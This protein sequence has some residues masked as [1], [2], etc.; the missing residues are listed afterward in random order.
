MILATRCQGLSKG[1]ECKS[2]GLHIH[3]G[4]HHTAAFHSRMYIRLT[5]GYLFRK[6]NGSRNGPAAFELSTYL[7]STANHTPQTVCDTRLIVSNPGR[8][9]ARLIAL[10]ARTAK[11]M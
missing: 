10:T 4:F 11:K 1:E 3:H 9:A 6:G 5:T 7:D 2:G 8:V